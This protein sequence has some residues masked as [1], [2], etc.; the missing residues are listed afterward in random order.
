MS[1]ETKANL[2]IHQ[3]IC[4]PIWILVNLSLSTVINQNGVVVWSTYPKEYGKNCKLNSK[5]LDPIHLC[6]EDS[7]ITS[8]SGTQQI[9]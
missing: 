7:C 3:N 2:T 5:I 1:P 4:S 8:N 6:V 9:V